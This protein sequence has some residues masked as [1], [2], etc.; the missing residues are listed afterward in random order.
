MPWRRKAPY[1]EQRYAAEA[2]RLYAVLDQRV[3]DREYFSGACS[4]ADMATWLRISRYER[5]GIDWTDY[6]NLERWY[7]TSADLW[8]IC[9][10]F[11]CKTDDM[12]DSYE[13]F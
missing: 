11:S 12:I 5:Q 7:L 8:L 1:A 9:R 4:I 3:A 13:R 2:K 6:P 10:H